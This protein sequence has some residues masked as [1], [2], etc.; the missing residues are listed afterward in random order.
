VIAKPPVEPKLYWWLS[1]FEMALFNAGCSPMVSRILVSKPSASGASGFSRH[2]WT[3][4]PRDDDSSPPTDNARCN[5]NADSS[6]ILSR[7]T[8]YR[9]HQRD[10]RRRSQ[11]VNPGWKELQVALYSEIIFSMAKDSVARLK[12]FLETPRVRL[13]LPTRSKTRKDMELLSWTSQ[14]KSNQLRK[15]RRSPNQDWR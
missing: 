3:K 5:Q 1:S 13:S 8:P 11:S 14:E 7:P 10:F 6:N 2:A 12:N 9:K 4:S 15:N